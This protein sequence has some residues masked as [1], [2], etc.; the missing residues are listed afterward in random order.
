MERQSCMEFVIILANA[1][2]FTR[3][4]TM[5]HN[6]YKTKKGLSKVGLGNLPLQ[7]HKGRY[8]EGGGVSRSVFL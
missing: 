8:K 7:N 2:I 1:A 3:V 6:Q 4:D 5:L